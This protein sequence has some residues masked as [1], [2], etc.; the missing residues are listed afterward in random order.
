MDY[1]KYNCVNHHHNIPLI[2]I[3]VNVLNLNYNMKQYL[4]D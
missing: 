1:A 3:D 4:D 2:F